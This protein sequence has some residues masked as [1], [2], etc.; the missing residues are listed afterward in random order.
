[1]FEIGFL[2]RYIHYI[3]KIKAVQIYDRSQIGKFAKGTYIF[4][5]LN[6]VI[7]L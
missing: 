2:I 3:F 1:M 4:T 7:K 6:S 5:N